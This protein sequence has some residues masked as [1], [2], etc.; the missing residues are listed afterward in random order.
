MLGIL[1]DFAERVDLWYTEEITEYL[2]TDDPDD[3]STYGFDL[4]ALNIARGR[5]H[6][7]PGMHML[8]RLHFIN[9]IGVD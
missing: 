6:G 8:S 7:L 5:D 9:G 2:F 4:F 1:N 3:T